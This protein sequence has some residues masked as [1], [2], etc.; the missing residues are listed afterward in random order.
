MTT[1][2]TIPEYIAVEDRAD[3]VDGVD[4]KRLA[5]AALSVQSLQSIAHSRG[6]LWSTS[7]GQFPKTEQ[8]SFIDKAVLFLYNHTVIFGE[9]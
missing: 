2:I 9:P 1:D 3:W 4:K 5:A 6:R 7:C 8:D